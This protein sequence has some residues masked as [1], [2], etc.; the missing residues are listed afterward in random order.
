MAF[1]LKNIIFSYFGR[2]DGVIDSYKDG[3]GKGVLERFNEVMGDTYD[4][5]HP[6]IDLVAQNVL[7]ANT[8]FPKY[9]PTRE[10]EYGNE[11]MYPSATDLNVRRKVLHYMDALWNVKGT[12]K[13]LNSV[14]GLIGFHVLLTE[15]WGSYS[16][17]SNVTFDDVD[18]TW[19]MKC[20]N[21]SSYRIDLV[22]LNGSLTAVSQAELKG[23]QSVEQINR[24]YDCVLKGIWFNG[25][26][27]A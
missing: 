5:F 21:C 16:F 7:A 27:I 2:H 24:P 15:Y 10:Y 9:L 22:R 14:L 19:D 20:Q 18:R 8:C 4:E 3:N 6:F 1:S 23:I 17:D 26:Q 12:H 11:S 13:F 25:T